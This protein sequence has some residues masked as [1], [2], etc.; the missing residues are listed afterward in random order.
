MIKLSRLKF[1][2]RGQLENDYS[3]DEV[4]SEV[5]QIYNNMDH[6]TIRRADRALIK[7]VES[8]GKVG[9]LLLGIIDDD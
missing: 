7:K 2:F 5:W 6:N 4:P 1:I 9:K 8:Y 3:D